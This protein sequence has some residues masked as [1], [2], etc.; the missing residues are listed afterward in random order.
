ML[1]IEDNVINTLLQTNSNNAHQEIHTADILTSDMT[2]KL[3]HRHAQ[4]THHNQRR[5]KKKSTVSEKCKS[6]SLEENKATDT[7]TREETTCNLK[8]T[9]MISLVGTASKK[10]IHTQEIKIKTHKI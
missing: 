5:W 3:L 2:H 6:S 9:P 10:H 1:Y 8:Y 4:N 7:F